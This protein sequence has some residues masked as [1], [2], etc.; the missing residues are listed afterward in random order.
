MHVVVDLLLQAVGGDIA[1]HH[2]LCQSAV[3]VQQR[4]QGAFKFIFGLLG[5]TLDFVAQQIEIL[6]ENLKSVF[7]PVPFDRLMKCNF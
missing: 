2:L 4:V 5:K 7:F 6:I 1:G 3:I